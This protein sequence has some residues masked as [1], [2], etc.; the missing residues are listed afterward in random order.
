MN[1]EFKTELLQ[2][3]DKHNQ[4]GNYSRNKS[5]REKYKKMRDEGMTGKAAREKLSEEFFSSE[6]TIETVLY[7][8][9]EIQ[10]KI[11]G[12]GSNKVIVI[13]E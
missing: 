10:V 1:Q 11:F 3:L 5:I 13:T 8:K 7:T 6:K 4:I 2:L 9:N 12:D